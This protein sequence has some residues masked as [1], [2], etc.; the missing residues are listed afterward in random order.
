MSTSIIILMLLICFVLPFVLGEVFS[1]LLKAKDLAMRIS[2]ALLAIFLGL[3]PFGYR[4]AMEEPLS[5]AI[6]LGIDLAGGTNLVYQVDTEAAEKGEKEINSQ[7]MEL[8]VSAIR[9]RI[10]K[11]G[12][13]EVTVRKVGANR[14][15]VIVP[16]VDADDVE[17]IKRRITNLGSLKFGIL[18][19]DYDDTDIKAAALQLAPEEVDVR[20]GGKVRAQWTN[21]GRDREGKRK[22]LKL[23]GEGRVF[24]RTVDI[25]KEDGELGK[26]TVTQYL[27]RVEDENR[28]VT[29]EFLTRAYEQIGNDGGKVVGFNF[30]RTGAHRFQDLTSRNRIRKDGSRRH[31]AVILNGE[32]HSAPTLEG[33]I[34]SSG[35]ISGDFSPKEL[36]EL[37]AVLNAGALDLPLLR[38]PVNEFSISPL[39]G[40]DVREKGKTALIIAAVAVLVFML[41]YYW[42][43]GA[44]ANVCLIINIVLVLGAMALIKATFTLPGLAGLVLTIGM[45][46]DAN[47]L[48][49]E[50]IREELA[51][52]SSLTSWR[53]IM[54]LAVR[55]RRLWMRT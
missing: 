25:P 2:F 29:G 33:V 35:S 26:E 30:N 9:R 28:E 14:V 12:V 5:G 10:N 13:E 20:I 52:G 55:L 40:I 50:R 15:E 8:L 38:D 24:N 7:S 23:G 3:A 4:L 43:A 45:A 31:L 22:V 36:K 49:F 11:G 18:A 21:A 6:K 44:V 32:I 34:S 48:I 16:G 1:R 46:V 42:F 17:E 37:T 54:D 41:V 39:L 51:K 47:V 19:N 53:F 27:V